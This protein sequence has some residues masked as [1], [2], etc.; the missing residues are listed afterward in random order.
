MPTYIDFF[1]KVRKS[2]FISP[3]TGGYVRGFFLD[4]INRTYPELANKLHSS[5]GIKPYSVR[6]LRPIGKKMQVIKGGWKLEKDDQVTFGVA[7]IKEGLEKVVLDSLLDTDRFTFGNI[8]CELEK[9]TVKKNDFK[10][11]ASKVFGPRIGIEFKTPTILKS[12]G[13]KHPYLF[14][15]PKKIVSNLVKIWNSFTPSDLK[16]PTERII[17]WAEAGIITRS[18][19]LMTREVIIENVRIPGF[20]GRVEWVIAEAEKGLLT[21]LTPLLLL[22]EY[23]NIGQKRTYGLGVAKVTDLTI[24]K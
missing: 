19:E 1:L 5:K 18:Y 2:G 13:F 22:S 6:P 15:E 24:K 3:F 12:P 10:D 16:M 20:K 23:S 4:T 8:T 14:P 7:L 11:F 17:E 21:Y 9:I